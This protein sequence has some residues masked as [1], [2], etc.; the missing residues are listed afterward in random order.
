MHQLEGETGEAGHRAGDV[1]DH[2][3]LRLGR[4][5]AAEARF[6]RHAAVAQRAAHGG[7]EVELTP[8]VAAP[9]HGQP[10]G[11]RPGQ[12]ADGALEGGH[13][14]PGGVHEL[15]VLRQLGPQAVGHRLRPPVGDQPPADL[16]LHLLPQPLDPGRQ[17]LPG[18]PLRQFVGEAAPACLD[19]FLGEL[20]HEP[21]EETVEVEGPQRAVEVVGAAHRPA[22]L[23]PGVAGDGGGGEGPQG[24]GV[25]DGPHQHGGQLLGRGVA[26]RSP[27]GHHPRDRRAAARPPARP[28]RPVVVAVEGEGLEGEV[29]VEEDVEDLLVVGVL[30]QRGLQRRLERRPVLDGDVLEGPHGVEVLR[31]RDRQPGGPQL[32]D[33]AR[34]QV[35]HSTRR[36]HVEG[37]GVAHRLTPR[38]PCL[39]GYPRSRA[40]PCWPVRCR[41]GT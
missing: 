1:G 23:H 36:R 20:L 37:R 24:V 8:V 3:D 13:L 2:H 25:E 31:H 5:G 10:S 19:S 14:L 15:D 29:H 12:R 27:A 18:Q 30:D 26:A 33:E 28:V 11:Q 32:V 16:G 34:D 38:R 17:L 39:G 6:S 41:A 40:A 22:R 35:E 21:V 4:V 9:A 7:P